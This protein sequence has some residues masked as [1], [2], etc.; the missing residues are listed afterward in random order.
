VV[1]L[2]TPFIDRGYDLLESEDL[3]RKAFLLYAVALSLL[4][5]PMPMASEQRSPD[6][7]RIF[8]YDRNQS[9]DIQMSK[10]YDSDG[11]QV[12]DLTYASPNG[13]RVPAYLVIPRGKGPFAG[14]VFGHWGNGNRTEF[15]PEAELYAQAGAVSILPS[16]PWSRPA[17][18][19]RGLATLVNPTIDREVYVQA[20]VDLRRAFDLTSGKI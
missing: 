14:I 7:D 20:V 8:D 3:M 5:C 12:Y 6:M 16:Y 11:G 2:I 17:P 4:T 13:G 1:A 19:Y 10:L 9:L 18:W 15:L